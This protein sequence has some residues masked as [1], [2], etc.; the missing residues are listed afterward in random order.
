MNYMYVDR[1][2]PWLLGD[3]QY[4]VVSILTC[5]S[6]KQTLGIVYYT[7]IVP[8]FFKVQELRMHVT[9]RWVTS[10]P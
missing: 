10:Y 6:A 1:Q 2:D 3:I 9:F 4:V 5:I 7:G 8:E